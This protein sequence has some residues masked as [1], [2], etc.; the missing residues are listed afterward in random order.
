MNVT[1]S[2]LG[3]LELA[4]SPF[5]SGG[6]G[7][8]YRATDS[9]GAVYCVKILTKQKPG[10]IE[11]IKHMSENPP[12]SLKAGW[13]T[14]CWPIDL[15]KEYGTGKYIGYVM[16]M[17]LADSVELSN[18]TNIRWPG[19]NLPPLAAKLDRTSPN[20]LTARML[21]ACNISA[22]VDR[23]H[24][25]GCVFVDLK[26][27]NILVS[28]RGHISLVDLDSLQ[29]VSGREIFRGPLGSP[30][31][32][33]SESYKMDFNQGPKIEPSWD[34]F[35]LAVIHY[36]I[37][38]GIHPFTASPKPSIIGCETIEDAIR[39]K[40]YVH[41]NNRSNLE[42]IPAPHSA[43][44]VVPTELAS[45]FKRAFDAVSP[46]QRPT[47]KEWGVALH[48]AAKGG[49][50]VLSKAIF[51]VPP[52]VVPRRRIQASPPAPVPPPLISRQSSG[53]WTPTPS[54]SNAPTPTPAPQPA[55]KSDELPAGCWFWIILGLI[56]MFVAMKK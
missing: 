8:V 9:A 2:K 43:I 40:M 45:L 38:L 21:I 20:G 53:S 17:A 4:D 10:E 25:L 31:Y 33:P 35:S 23:I 36:E 30:E 7:E 22:A 52:P 16:P 12:S 18:L 32:M 24:Q 37:L 11:K 56:W 27:Q 39:F 51:S 5:A 50:P 6:A 14:L 28:P 19:K 1:S 42:V 49:A 29:I 13:G 3:R 15:V 55:K 34:L 48:D 41:G 26:P 54:R 46:A 44:N 47:A